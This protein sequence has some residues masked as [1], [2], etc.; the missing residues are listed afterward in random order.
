MYFHKFQ[1]NFGGDPKQA[2]YHTSY[3]SR[4]QS[5]CIGVIFSYG[6]HM[7]IA[8]LSTK[9]LP[10]F[11]KAEYI[12]YN[13]VHISTFHSVI[14]YEIWFSFPRNTLYFHKHS[15]HESLSLY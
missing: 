15:I 14:L 11:L 10:I 6:N 13:F 1:I 9:C 4:T 5:S 12:T 8:E 7:H 2:H 3:L